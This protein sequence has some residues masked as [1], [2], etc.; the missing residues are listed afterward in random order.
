MDIL[1]TGGTGFLGKHLVRGLLGAGHRVRLMGRG[2][3]DVGIRALLEAGAAPVKA[4]LRD[5][6]AVSDACRGVEVVFHVGALSAPWGKREEFFDTN[7]G[8]TRS[9]VAGC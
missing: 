1:V 7:L 4:D 2:V 9:V 5:H 8:G 3:D 6:E